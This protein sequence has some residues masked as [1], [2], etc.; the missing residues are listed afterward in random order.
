[1][2]P[3]TRASPVFQ[4][5]RHF[6][7]PRPHR[8]RYAQVQQ[9]FS[10]RL[11]L[12]VQPKLGRCLEW[13]LAPYSRRGDS[14]TQQVDPYTLSRNYR[15]SDYDVR[16]NISANFYYTLIN[17]KTQNRTEHADRWREHRWHNLL[18]NRQPFSVYN[19]RITDCLFGNTT[20]FDGCSCG[21][22]RR[23]KQ[24]PGFPFRFSEVKPY[25][26]TSPAVSNTLIFLE[27]HVLEREDPVLEVRRFH[28]YEPGLSEGVRQH[29]HTLRRGEKVHGERA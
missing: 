5:C 9:G 22:S 23:A 24:Y 14:I 10:R 27:E 19:S 7:L 28:V 4:K 20:Y 3:L 15:T 25:A 17:I 6:Q 8:Q 2:P 1:M 11:Q 18:S 29:R 16:H 13:R 26:R 21:P 12:Y